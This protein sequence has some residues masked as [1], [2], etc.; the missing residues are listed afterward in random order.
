MAHAF[1]GTLQ[2]PGRIVEGRSMEKADIYMSTEGVDVPKRRIP[3]ARSGMAIV[4]K[5]A[6]IR[7]AGAHP[8]KPWQGERSQRVI[9]PGKP[10]VN[11][12][13]APDGAREPKEFAHGLRPQQKSYAAMAYTRR[14]PRT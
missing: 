6:N 13:V 2:Q 11:C 4:Q 5:L 3:Y 14:V 7:S 9:S 10:S 8:V 1:A 12:R